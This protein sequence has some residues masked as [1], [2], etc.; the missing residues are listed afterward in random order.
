MDLVVTCSGL[1]KRYNKVV[2][3]KDVS[4]EIPV[5]SL[6][7]I[8]GPNG[9]GKSTLIK[10]ISGLVKPTKGRVEVLG[11]DPWKYRHKIFKKL[12]VMFEDHSPPDWATAKEYLIYKARLKGAEDP[13]R[14][15]MRAAEVFDVTDYWEQEISTY[16]S[17]MRRK[18]A[19]ADAL[20]GDPDLLILD[21]PTVALDKESR[22]TLKEILET[23]LNGGKT[24]I[25]SSH[26]IA[27]IENIATHL[28][29]IHMGELLLKGQIKNITKKLELYTLSIKTKQSTKLIETLIKNKIDFTVE[30]DRII[31]KGVTEEEL[32]RI[33]RRE[34]IKAEV[35][36]TP[37]D[38]WQIY[39]KTL[40]VR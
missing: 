34:D 21:D 20:I 9:S 24:T 8:M 11:M 10:I 26:I 3:L 16:S 35:T 36:E 22:I 27:E 1:W 23:R 13:Y 28:A 33:L 31:T 2:A 17:G 40:S 29:I 15:A 32:Y 4:L 18:L 25:V 12:G 39:V 7:L 38:I 30:K 5:N 6:F 14:E 37:T 19:L